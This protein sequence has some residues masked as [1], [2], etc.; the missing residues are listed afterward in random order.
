MNDKL[1]TLLDIEEIRNPRI[2]Y[3]H[4]LDG[5]RLQSLD[6]VF[7][8]DAIVATAGGVWRGNHRYNLRDCHQHFPECTV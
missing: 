7:T 2:L 4:H 1:Q 5:N 8:S 3:S 6:Q